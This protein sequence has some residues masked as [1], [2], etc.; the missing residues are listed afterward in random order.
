MLFPLLVRFLVN[1]LVDV[2]KLIKMYL[3][4]NEW[5]FIYFWLL[6]ALGVY[7]TKTGMR[8]AIF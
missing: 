6:A 3:L 7:S 2:P 8:S 4:V 1:L 5:Y